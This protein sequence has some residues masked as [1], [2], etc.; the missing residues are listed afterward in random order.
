[1][2][3][4]KTSLFYKILFLTK[5]DLNYLFTMTMTLNKKCQSVLVQFTSYIKIG[6]PLIHNYMFFNLLIFSVGY[7]RESWIQIGRLTILARLVFK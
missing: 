6:I 7:R 3:S 4:P 1:M 2:L 5:K